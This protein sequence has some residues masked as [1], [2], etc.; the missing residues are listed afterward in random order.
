MQDGSGRVTVQRLGKRVGTLAVVDELTFTAGPGVVTGLLGPRGAGK[1]TALRMLLGLVRPTA[2]EALIDGRPF[3]ALDRPARM[4]GA[5][6]EGPGFHPARSGR[7]HLRACATAIGAPGNLVEHALNTV[8]LTDVA[9][10]RVARYPQ[11]MRQRLALATALLGDPRVLVL[12]EPGAGLDPAGR[13][14]LR[15]FLRGFAG[16][17]RTVLLSG[18]Q[19]GELEQACDR[20]V[21]LN[22]GRCVHQGDRA[23]LSSAYRLRALVSC[24]TPVAL[25]EALA[26]AGIAEID[27]LPA[28]WLAVTG[29]DADRVAEVA[30][31]AGIGLHELRQEPLDLDRLATGPPTWDDPTR[32]I[33]GRPPR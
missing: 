5:V 9:D 6:L 25:A 1:S 7:T 3:G 33:A 32:P 15:A 17:G 4:V 22:R 13:A 19:L 14:W 20:V 10:Q 2:G 28:G 24:P 21:V 23:T 8:G 11:G 29:T 31:A 16:Q 27:L 12:D 30:A 26:G 18:R